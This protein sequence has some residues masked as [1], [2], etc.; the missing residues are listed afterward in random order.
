MGRS[1]A[2]A[3]ALGR[4]RVLLLGVRQPFH[5]I[6]RLLGRSHHEGCSEELRELNS[7]AQVHWQSRSTK[8]SWV[9]GV[10]QAQP[11][12]EGDPTLCSLVP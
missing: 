4:A 9:G 5:H 8:P 10:P 7:G 11:W 2:R 1:Q 12:S 3:S 6:S